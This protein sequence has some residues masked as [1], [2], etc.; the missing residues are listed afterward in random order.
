M[1][2]LVSIVIP[3]YNVGEYLEECLNSVL[4]QSYSNIEIILVDDGSSDDSLE[5]CFRFASKDR[6]IKVISQENGGLSVARNKGLDLVEG[7]FICFVDS[8]DI[9][10]PDF[11][12]VLLSYLVNNDAD[13]AMCR[14]RNFNNADEI[15][16]IGESTE[17]KTIIISGEEALNNLYTEGW[18]P[19]NIIAVNKLYRRFIWQD[20][21]YPVG[22]IHEDEYI[23]HHIYSQVRKIVSISIPLYY[24]RRRENSIMHSSISEKRIY[25][26]E[27]L[28]TSRR[29]FFTERANYELV[30]KTNDAETMTMA[31]LFLEKE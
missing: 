27:E 26:I 16:S 1:D 21:R 10:H 28:Y 14:Y 25:D 15:T 23:I 12:E 20:F 6:R 3:V 9:I 13:I 8:D 2:N 31:Q 7:E 24:Y 11:V 17:T 29:L 18:Y 5:L 19:N 22:K 4:A 30:G